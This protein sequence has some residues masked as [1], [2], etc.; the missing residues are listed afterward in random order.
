MP[1]IG[2]L[3]R[4]AGHCDELVTVDRGA[5]TALRMGAEPSLHVGDD[6]SISKNALRKLKCG[7]KIKLPRDKSV[8][9]LE[10][11]LDLLPRSARVI[12]VGSHRD[13]EGR[14]DH[15][16]VNFL[17]ASRRKNLFLADERMWIANIDG[18]KFEFAAERGTT[19][20]MIPLG[21]TAVTVRGARYE[22][23]GG[24]LAKISS[25]L[26][27]VTKKS[28][29]RVSSRGPALLFVYKNILSCRC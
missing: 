28:R 22:M 2:F 1:G 17:L 5:E 13:D 14:S 10:F 16:F 6:D 29:V 24:K 18:E 4:L 8:S 11:A 19:F 7:T 23:S 21:K 20:S 9:D 26:S 15:V 27:N 25:G 12:V 3:R